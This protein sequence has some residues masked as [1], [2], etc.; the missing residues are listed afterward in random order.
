MQKVEGTTRT[1]LRPTVRRGIHTMP[2][3]PTTTAGA[4]GSAVHVRQRVCGG[5]EQLRPLTIPRPCGMMGADEQ[6]AIII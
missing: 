2:R 6:E 5:G 1:G 4:G 3:I